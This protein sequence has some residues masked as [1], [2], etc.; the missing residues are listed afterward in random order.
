MPYE[1]LIAITNP[2]FY[3]EPVITGDYENFGFEIAIQMFLCGLETLLYDI[4]KA[5]AENSVTIASIFV[6]FGLLTFSI[7]RFNR[8]S[9]IRNLLSRLM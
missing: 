2:C 6:G 8:V 4:G 7:M 3:G 1:E 5:I 9:I